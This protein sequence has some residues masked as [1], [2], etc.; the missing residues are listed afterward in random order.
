MI[1]S[2]IRR[3]VVD[4]RQL[5]RDLRELEAKKR[6][7]IDLIADDVL[8][9]CDP[10][11]A[12]KLGVEETDLTGSAEAAPQGEP[13]M[14]YNLNLWEWNF[15]LENSVQPFCKKTGAEFGSRHHPFGRSR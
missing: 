6:R 3:E 2:S 5:D 12:R 15:E 4:T 13:F 8:G 14:L 7:L 9:K 10:G 11:L 1:H